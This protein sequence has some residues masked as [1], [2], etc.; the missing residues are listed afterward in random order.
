MKSILGI[1]FILCQQNFKLKIWFIWLILINNNTVFF[2]QTPTCGTNILWKNLDSEIQ[3]QLNHNLLLLNQYN[4]DKFKSRSNP[5]ISV[6]VHVVWYKLE[7]NITDESIRGQIEILNNDYNSKNEDLK[8]VPLEFNPFIAKSGIRF[9]LASVNPE[10]VTIP[11]IIRKRTTIEK[12]GIK[13]ELFSDVLGGSD[14][15]DTKRYLNIWVA[16]T[17]ENLTGFG[18]FPGL[19]SIE[20][21]GVVIKPKYF[22][23]SDVSTRYNLGRVAVHEIGHYLGLSHIWGSDESC[24]NDDGIE[25]TPPQSHEYIGCPAYPQYSCDNSNMFMNFM[26]YVDDRCMIFFTRGQ[27][28]RMNATLELFRPLLLNSEIPCVSN[29]DS[30][31]IS[32]FEV[33]PNPSIGQVN[34]EFNG[35]VSTWSSIKVYNSIGCL[36]FQRNGV[37]FNKMFVDF[38]ITIRGIYI[39]RIGNAS[40][41]IIVI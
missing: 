23:Y 27:M 5:I 2:A 34:I 37:I 16:D 29:E 14:A 19:V 30:E 13:D 10:G 21:D 7:D 33:Y 39:V 18:S 31:N 25:D 41:K 36:V 38:G 24:G 8:N 12:I 35:D 4:Q 1:Y 32:E 3:N 22:G 40:R 6:V 11:G 17:G 9:C 20:K 28:V 26:D 15:W